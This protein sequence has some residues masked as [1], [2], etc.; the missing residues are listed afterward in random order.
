MCTRHSVLHVVHQLHMYVA[1]L[2]IFYILNGVAEVKE[3]HRCKDSVAGVTIANDLPRT[4]C[5]EALLPALENVLLA[6]AAAR[7]SWKR[8]CVG[9]RNGP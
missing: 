8:W 3:G 7:S 1:Y 6:F 2:K 9:R 4:G 5:D